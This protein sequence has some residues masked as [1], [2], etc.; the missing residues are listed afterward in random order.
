[1]AHSAVIGDGP[2]RFTRKNG[3]MILI[4][5]SQ[6]Y[7]DD[8]GVL[9]RDP[10][11]P[12][13]GS[14]LLDFLNFL[15]LSGQLTKADSP[16]PQAALLIA[17]AEAGAVYNGVSIDIEKISGTA[18]ATVKFDVT[19]SK[20]DTYTGLS[21]DSSS[22]AAKAAPNYMA[23]VLG[24]ELGAGTSPSLVRAISADTPTQPAAIASPGTKFKD[25]GAGKIATL[26]VPGDPSGTAFNLQAFKAGS[27]GGLITIQIANVKKVEMTFDLTVTWSKTLTATTSSDFEKDK[28]CG[29]LIKVTDP[30]SGLGVPRPGMVVMTGA[31]D[32]T[33]AGATVFTP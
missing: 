9:T 8:T 26:A 19:V 11:A 17:A 10:L 20:S 6:L 28:E 5:L 18:P 21:W 29:Y 22:A 4:P 30:P 25:N 12:P 33:S 3:S 31:V 16:P 27:P 23:N 2:V 24:T 14:E 13:E 1:M 15:V 32:A 7:F